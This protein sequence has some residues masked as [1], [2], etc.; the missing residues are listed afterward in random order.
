MATVVSQKPGTSWYFVLR[1]TENQKQL[2]KVQATDHRQVLNEYL[3]YSF[4]LEPSEEI[5]Y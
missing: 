2:W 3:Q 4:A 5:G 1:F